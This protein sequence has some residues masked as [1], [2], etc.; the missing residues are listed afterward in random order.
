MGGDGSIWRP[1]L[2]WTTE[3]IVF[4][5][6]APCCSSRWISSQKQRESRLLTTCCCFCNSNSHITGSCSHKAYCKVC[7]QQKKKKKKKRWRVKK[8]KQKKKTFTWQA[9]TICIK[10][11]FGQYPDIS[12]K[13]DEMCLPYADYKNKHK[14]VARRGQD[15]LHIR[16]LNF[17][18][19]ILYTMPRGSTCLNKACKHSKKGQRPRDT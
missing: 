13:Q 7:C 15:R 3:H 12:R 6:F 10:E 1:L 4:V 14:T 11:N 17:I 18:C 2:H 9:E 8:Q 19:G 16:C 5:P